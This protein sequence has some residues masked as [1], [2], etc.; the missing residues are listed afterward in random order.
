MPDSDCL[1]G[2]KIGIF[3]QLVALSHPCDFM[4][5][6]PAAGPVTTRSEALDRIKTAIPSLILEYRQLSKLVSTYLVAGL[7]YAIGAWFLIGRIGSASPQAGQLANLDT[8]TAVNL[9][10]RFF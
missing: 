6:Q 2:I 8:I 10:Y 4:K 9:V 5:K 3:P 7:V 1:R